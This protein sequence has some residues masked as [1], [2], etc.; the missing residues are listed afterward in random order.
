MSDLKDKIKAAIISNNVSEAV[1]CIDLYVK[2]GGKIDDPLANPPEAEKNWNL[3]F[4][5]S[6][7]DSDQVLNHILTN[8]NVKI[9]PVD[10]TGYTPLHLAAFHGKLNCVK[11]LIEHGADLSKASTYGETLYELVIQRPYLQGDNLEI[12]EFIQKKLAER[13]LLRS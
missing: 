9:D 7:C 3:L 10:T 11:I 12:K 2:Q 5:A 8:Y 4:W 6:L 1:E 13:G